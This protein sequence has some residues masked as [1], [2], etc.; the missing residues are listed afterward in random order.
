MAEFIMKD[1]IRKKRM[2]EDFCVESAAA[3][4]EEIGNDMYP[5]A[6]LK[7]AEKHI[8]YKKRAAR[9]ITRKD[10]DMYDYIYY[11][12]N[13]NEHSVRKILGKDPNHKIARLLP[14]REVADPWYTDDFETA[15]QDIREGCEYRLAEILEDNAWNIHPEEDDEENNILKTLVF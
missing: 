4:S 9:K 13:E 14:N 3:S 7:L 1:L 8:P 2:S 12:D 10:Y 15:Y 5:P 6:K 11:M